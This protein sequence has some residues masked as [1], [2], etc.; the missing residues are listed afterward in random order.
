LVDGIQGLGDLL[1][2]GQG[3][4]KI[5]E[6]R[7]RSERLG[8]AQKM[9]GLGTGL[10]NG[11]NLLITQ[12]T[13]WVILCYAIK[14]VG[15]K[16]L[17]GVLLPVIALIVLASFEA[18]NPLGTAAQYLQSSLEAAKRL[19]ELSD[20]RATIIEPARPLP[21]PKNPWIRFSHLTF[22]YDLNSQ[23]VLNDFCLDLPEG[24]H[25]ALIGTNGSGKS[26]IVNLLQRFWDYDFGSIQLNGCELKDLSSYDIRRTIGVKPQSIY[27]FSGTVAENLQMA[28]PGAADKV[29]IAALR[30]A[31]LMEWLDN[32][33]QG[34]NTWIGEHGLK[35]SG[36]ERQR[37]AIARTLLRDSPIV[38][39]DEPTE[40]LELFTEM[41]LVR[42]LQLSLRE[43]TVLW[44]S[45][46]LMGLEK[47]D[48][49][50][51][52]KNGR[53]L[54]QGRHE[55]LIQSGGTY[56]RIWALHTQEI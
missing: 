41:A 49:I 51:V 12:L 34:L 54:E 14:L 40:H 21:V 15:T 44:I 43:R 33:P 37:L 16:Q 38:I 17:E 32:L 35:L 29:L 10:T 47:M 7:Q 20:S 25:T 36:G 45:H 42:E 5:Y 56:A 2:N 1:A 48:Q 50:V 55:V 19:F 4:S 3:T 27:L 18:V 9:L 30:K 8:R 53:V 39:L 22:R 31:C 52:L 23:P 46:R 24:I 6:I 13:L 26:T 11:I 28:Q